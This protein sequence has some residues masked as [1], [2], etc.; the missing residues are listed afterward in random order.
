MKLPRIKKRFWIPALVL[1]VLISAGAVIQMLFSNIIIHFDATEFSSDEIDDTS[2]GIS[3]VPFPSSIEEVDQ[4]IHQAQTGLVAIVEPFGLRKNMLFLWTLTGQIRELSPFRTYGD[5]SP[6]QKKPKYYLSGHVETKA[7][8]VDVLYQTEAT[9]FT[10]GDTVTLCEQYYL[11]DRR[12]PVLLERIGGGPIR[13]FI[14]YYNH[15]EGITYAPIENNETYLIWG[16]YSI[17]EKTYLYEK[18]VENP[19]LGQ[20]VTRNT[21][22]VCL[23]D[24]EKGVGYTSTRPDFRKDLMLK[25]Y[26]YAIEHYGDQISAYVNE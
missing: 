8:I 16:A 3:D 14:K 26:E 6:F 1:T 10:D 12:I 5:P 18:E 9:N 2:Y 4:R 24:P 15:A 23:S 11:V 25:R 17:N 21:G 22:I 13:R 7:K 19:N 20:I